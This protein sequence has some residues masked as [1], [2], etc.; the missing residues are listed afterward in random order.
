MT[1][2]SRGQTARSRL[3]KALVAE[4]VVPFLG[5]GF[6]YGARHPEAGWTSE[7]LRMS[8]QLKRWLGE[9]IPCERGCDPG[10]GQTLCNLR[11]G[12]SLCHL[13]ELGHTLFGAR[14]VCETLHIHEYADLRPEPQH[15]YLAYLARE[16][17]VNEIITSNYDCC[18]ETAFAESFDPGNAGEQLGVVRNLEEYRQTGSRYRRAGQLI[19]Y[20][21][22]GCA[23]AYTLARQT[24]CRS[25]TSENKES[26]N[27]E[28]QRIILT[29]RQLQTFRD[30]SWAR[31]MVR[32]RF[33]SRH[34]FFSGFG[35]DEPQIRHTVLTLIEEFAGRRTA[36]PGVSPEDA[37]ELP[38]APFLHSH[39]GTLSFNQ[40]Q[41]LVAFMDAHS[42]A[43]LGLEPP[44]DRLRPLYRNILAP[45]RSDKELDASCMMQEVFQD[46]FLDL[47]RNALEEGRP[48]SLW[49]REATPEWRAWTGLLHRVMDPERRRRLLR[50]RLLS[51]VG[52]EQCFPLGLYRYLWCI[53][54]PASL[55]AN[56]HTFPVGWYMPLRE[57]PLFILLA[58]LWLCLFCRRRHEPHLTAFGL[59]L[60]LP[61]GGKV[62]LI[63][64]DALRE[65][66][67]DTMEDSQSRLLRLIIIPSLRQDVDGWGRWRRVQDG[68][69]CAGRWIAIESGDLIR[70]A[71]RPQHVNEPMVWETFAAAPPRRPAARIRPLSGSNLRG[72]G[73]GGLS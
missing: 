40:L 41:M 39:D 14:R 9:V 44:A 61:S 21:I 52:V 31:D 50:R 38:N 34:L 65:L 11:V 58:L 24:Y 19:L 43:R 51:P 53:R 35:N 54:Y 42:A 47:V 2:R 12:S 56:N 71:G 55:A 25:R 48:F 32:D 73:N 49:L 23:K 26:W 33:R 4:S 30:Q 7:P 16:G 57:D 63:A 72:E 8:L 60:R 27:A 59:C 28:A 5:A 46:V 66:Q 17:L 36:P 62:H 37:M 69:L 1:L 45:E 10:P 13:A 15:R 67:T 22:N 68:H 3:V 70:K 6:T 18:I 20:K 29:E 64:R